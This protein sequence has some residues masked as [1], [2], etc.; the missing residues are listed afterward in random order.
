M[1]FTKRAIENIS[2]VCT[3]QVFFD[4]KFT[5]LALKV[6][7]SGKKSFHYCYR[8]QK[9]RRAD[10][11]WLLLGSLPVITVDQAR[12]AA[13]EKAALVLSG[14]D[15]AAT[16]QADKEAL[17]MHEAL[18][19]FKEEHV[20]RL[21]PKTQL[22]YNDLT[23][24]CIIPKKKN[25]LI[26]QISYTHIASFHSGMK[27]TPYLGNRALAVF[28]KFFGWCELHGYREKNSNPAQGVQKHKKIKRQHLM[29]KKEKE[30]YE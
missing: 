9:G 2:P 28:S 6:G 20:S 17:K 18:A 11:K 7:K 24:R 25:K 8:A 14:E 10:K 27:N 12:E 21:K 1:K 5:G 23:D 13:K 3:R 4:S 16:I 19:V 26:K 30:F 15:P 22:Q 29:G